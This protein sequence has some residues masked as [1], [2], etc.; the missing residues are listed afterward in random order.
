MTEVDALELAAWNLATGRLVSE[1]LPQLATDA[2]L[3]GVDTP[4]LRMLAGQQPGDVRDSADLFIAV[5]DEVGIDLPDPE[6]AHW[7]LVRRTA[8]EVIARR[9]SPGRGANELW[10]AYHH[11]RDSGDLRTFVGLASMLDDYPEDEARIEAQI[12]AEVEQL[13]ARPAPRVWIKLMAARGRSTIT[14]TVGV[15]DVEVD[16][17][18]LLLGDDLRSALA[19]WEHQYRNT[20]S[21]WPESGGFASERDAE[22][23]VTEGHLLVTRLQ[24]D[25]GSG[26]YVEYMPEPIRPPGVKLRARRS[27]WIMRRRPRR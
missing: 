18:S 27:G 4:S 9:M 17:D 24:A 1:D 2:L 8:I 15:V 10:A 23:F 6:C 20:L 14:R 16:P 7:K 21:N 11:V 19:R 13:L 12:L 5:L 22:D 3:R 26:Y 25:L